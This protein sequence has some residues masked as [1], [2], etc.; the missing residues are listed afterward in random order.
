MHDKVVKKQ[1]E[2][3]VEQD[4]KCQTENIGIS[5]VNAVHE[6]TDGRQAEYHTEK[7]IFFERMIV[8]GVMGFMPGPEKAVHDI[9]MCPVCYEFPEEEGGNGDESA[10]QVDHGKKVNYK[11]S[12]ATITIYKTKFWI[13]ENQLFR[14]SVFLIEFWL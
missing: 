3:S 14:C 6:K 9:F 2:N 10:N 1:V 4:A 12:G 11:A 5:E 13:I 7:I 8:P